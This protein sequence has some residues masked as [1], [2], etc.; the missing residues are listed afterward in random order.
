MTGTVKENERKHAG[1]NCRNLPEKGDKNPEL[2]YHMRQV[3][4]KISDIL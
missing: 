3:L 1:K 2:P 4:P